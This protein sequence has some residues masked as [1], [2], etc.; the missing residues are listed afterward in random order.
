MLITLDTKSCLISPYSLSLLHRNHPL[1]ENDIYAIKLILK[2][3][4]HQQK[5]QRQFIG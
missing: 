5:K 2:K 1:R 3:W 4:V